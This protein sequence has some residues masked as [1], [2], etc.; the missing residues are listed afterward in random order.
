MNELVFSEAMWGIYQPLMRADFQ[1]FDQYTFQ[2][3]GAYLL[4]REK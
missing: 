3:E 2:H 1:L 4:A